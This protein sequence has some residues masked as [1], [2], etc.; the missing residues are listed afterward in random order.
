M[1]STACL[2]LILVDD[3]SL[4]KYVQCIN[5]MSLVKVMGNSF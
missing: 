3:A 2:K 4:H 1:R 5:R